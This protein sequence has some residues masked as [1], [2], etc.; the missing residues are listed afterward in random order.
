MMRMKPKQEDEPMQLA[1]RRPRPPRTSSG[2]V[3]PGRGPFYPPSGEWRWH[4]E[5]RPGNTGLAVSE[6]ILPALTNQGKPCPETAAAPTSAH[7]QVRQ[8][9]HT[10]NITLPRS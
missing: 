2:T 8:Y 5:R 10:T 1:S 3:I 6:N 9:H 4:W 7:P